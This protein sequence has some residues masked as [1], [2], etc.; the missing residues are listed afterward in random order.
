VEDGDLWRWQVPGSREFYSGLS[1]LGLE[2][3]VAKNPAI[4]DTLVALQPAELVDKVRGGGRWGSSWVSAC[5][6][7]ARR[8][9]QPWLP[10]CCLPTCLP[11][12]LPA[13]LPPAGCRA[14]LSC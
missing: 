7:V 1:T 12:C 3:D 9:Q 13:C 6:C 14:S 10:R 11:A 2:Y 4:F 5:A 8:R